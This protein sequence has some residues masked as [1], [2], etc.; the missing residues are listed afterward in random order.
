MQ[1]GLGGMTSV[2]AEPRAPSL[3]PPDAH[4]F[5]KAAIFEGG[6]SSKPITQGEAPS[7]NDQNPWIVSDVDG[8]LVVQ[9]SRKV[10]SLLPSLRWNTGSMAWGV[11]APKL[12]LWEV[13]DHALGYTSLLDSIP[14][15]WW[16]RTWR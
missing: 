15:L 4:A 13:W 1:L 2:S 7:L 3:V 8:P 10:S 12:C 11:N 16:V 6:I 9:T 5:H 14:R